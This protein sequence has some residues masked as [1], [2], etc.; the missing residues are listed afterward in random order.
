M[1]STRQTFFDI[2][3]N[4][5]RL[6]RSIDHISKFDQDSDSDSMFVIIMHFSQN[7]KHFFLKN[8]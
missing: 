7:E 8:A 1:T 3:F 6:I 5:T 2:S 4:V